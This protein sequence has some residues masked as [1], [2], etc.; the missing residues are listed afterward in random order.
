MKTKA[1]NG[2][3]IGALVLSLSATS[4]ARAADPVA[5]GVGVT[6]LTVGA[7]FAGGNRDRDATS[8][9]TA[10]ALSGQGTPV[11]SSRQMAGVPE[12]Q[13]VILKCNAHGQHCR[14][15]PHH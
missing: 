6:L 3:A 10:Y 13:P 9:N 15:V 4:P 12:R 11:L 2:A 1:I 7:L 14:M 5:V 8:V